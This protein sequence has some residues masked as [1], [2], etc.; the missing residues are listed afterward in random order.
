MDDDLNSAAGVGGGAGAGVRAV[1]RWAVDAHTIT[2]REERGTRGEGFGFPGKCHKRP[3]RGPRS[4]M[5]WHATYKSSFS[6]L[7]TRRGFSSSPR[8]LL[9]AEIGVVCSQHEQNRGR[10]WEGGRG[11]C[12]ERREGSAGFRSVGSRVHELLRDHGES[13]LPCPRGDE[14]WPSCIVPEGHHRPIPPRAA[15]KG[16][17]DRHC[18]LPSISRQR[19]RKMSTTACLKAAALRSVM[20]SSQQHGH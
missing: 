10:R 12:W 6:S 5:R 16:L 20:S 3:P 4:N 18:A 15:A 1:Q 14:A 19:G 9:A 8:K 11:S 17:A 13:Q 2:A 7:L